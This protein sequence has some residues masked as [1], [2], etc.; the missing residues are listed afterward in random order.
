M[1]LCDGML[2]LGGSLQHTVP[3]VDLTPAEILVLQHIHG[4]GDALVDLRPT[5][6]DTRN[7][8]AEFD[9]LAGKYDRA[10]AAFSGPD[11]PKSIMSTLFPGAM[12]KLPVTLD[13][14]GMGYIMTGG[15]KPEPEAE[16]DLAPLAPLGA[17]ETNHGEDINPA[18][19][20]GTQVIVDQDDDLV[21][22]GDGNYDPEEA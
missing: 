17:Q 4:G 21:D 2:R 15:S 11:D 9:R 12:K 18:G 7:H 16:D 6:M 22:G 5:K 1:Q 13:D 8:T 20:G 14:I 19:D 3:M 10:N